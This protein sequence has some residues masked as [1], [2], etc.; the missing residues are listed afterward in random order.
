MTSI[1]I[2]G[3]IK[4][5]GNVAAVA[6]IDLEAAS[7]ELV[8]LLGPSGCGKTT[9]LRCIAGLESASAGEI[10]IGDTLVSSSNVQMPPE[11]RAI[12]MVFQS[13]ALWPHMTVAEN[14]GLGLKLHGVARED[15]R[16]RV[17]DALELVGMGSFGARNAG[18]LSG[19]QQQRVALARAVV[20]EPKIL[21]FD[22]PLSNLDAKMRERM[23]GEIRRLQKRLGITAIYVTH[24]QQEAMVIADRVV[25]M[26]S[27]RIAQIGAPREIYDRP[28]S[29]FAAN[30]IGSANIVS[31]V[32]SSIGAEVSVDLGAGSLNAASAGTHAVGETVDLV[33]RPEHV[34][35][36]T[37]A[38]PGPNV[39]SGR[40]AEVIFLG[41]MG[42]V[43]VDIGP[44]RLRVQTSP[45]GHW[46]VGDRVW[47]HFAAGNIVVLNKQE[48][49]ES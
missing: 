44:H 17:A 45:P 37:S 24:D 27:G 34:A 25:L 30:F 18:E 4:R 46:Q 3:L 48:D 5:H 22:E 41:N 9:T 39:L 26:Q 20:L 15:I 8:V 43:E 16:R 42:E 10:W 49:R 35:I 40:I 1:R 13:Y 6:G 14:L 12:G 2:S 38:T 28:A 31:G 33:I 36:S 21:L 11:K 23:R 47:L 29:R 19:G 7:G 32:V